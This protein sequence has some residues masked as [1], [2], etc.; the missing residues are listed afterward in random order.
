MSGMLVFNDRMP[1]R[2]AVDEL[3]LPV[4]CSKSAEWKEIVLYLPPQLDI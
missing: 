2:Q 1:I 4:D 3:L